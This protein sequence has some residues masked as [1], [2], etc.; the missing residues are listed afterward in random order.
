[1][2]QG[3]GYV[4]LYNYLTP[5]LGGLVSFVFLGEQFSVGQLVGAAIV[6]GGLLLERRGVALGEKKDADAKVAGDV[7]SPALGAALA[8]APA[9]AADEAEVVTVPGKT[10]LP[11]SL[12]G[13]AGE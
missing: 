9:T 10:G 2:R 12:E 3:V 7:V 13:Q 11:P 5:V 6:L 4:T 8:D 1:M